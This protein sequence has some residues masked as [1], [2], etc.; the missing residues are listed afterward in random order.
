MSLFYCVCFVLI[1]K[2]HEAPRD[3]EV[4]R[5]LP[6]AVSVQLWQ[7]QCLLAKA[8]LGTFA[9]IFRLEA[10]VWGFSLWSVRLGTFALDLSFGNFRLGS[11]A[12]YYQ[13]YSAWFWI[14]RLE[15]FAWDLPLGNFCLGS[16]GL[17]NWS[18]EAGGTGWLTLGEPGG[19]GSPH[20]VFEILSKNPSSEP[21]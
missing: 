12:W 21:S 5:S 8:R 2:W 6:V 14:F 17:G 20:S 10:F 19:T 7:A 15:A 16:L 1:V 11:F 13:L 9:W 4:A 18:P 3:C